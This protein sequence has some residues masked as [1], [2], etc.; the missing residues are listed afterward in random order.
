L[1]FITCICDGVMLGDSLDMAAP[2]YDIIHYRQIGVWRAVSLGN[3]VFI[4]TF[5]FGG[6]SLWR[7]DTKRGCEMKLT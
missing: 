1:S 2:L 7:M 4:P 5:A 3:A 6:R